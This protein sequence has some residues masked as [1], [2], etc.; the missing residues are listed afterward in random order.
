MII[1]N[2]SILSDFVQK[3]AQAAKSLNKWVEKIQAVEW[4]DHMNVKETFASASYIDNGRYAFNV[5]GNKY[6]VVALVLF[7]NGV[8]ELRFVGTHSEYDRIDCSTI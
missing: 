1:S 6:R 5:G 8:M 2:K 4:K 7:F 3:H